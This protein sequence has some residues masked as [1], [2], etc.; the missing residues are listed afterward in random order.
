MKKIISVIGIFLVLVLA[1]VYFYFS[2]KEYVVEI[3]EA[4]IRAKIA[5]KI[6]LTKSFL[7][8]FRV[9][10]KNPRIE[11]VNGSNRINGGFDVVL[12]IRLGKEAKNLGGSLDISGGVRYVPESG[13]FY[14][15]DPIIENLSVTGI[16]NIH[17]KSVTK[18][19]SKIL[20]EFY[21]E[22]PIYTLDGFKAKESAVKMILK[23]IVVEEKS[24]VIT[25]G[26]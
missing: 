18:G 2:G 24:L 26:I 10:L 11:L 14:L 21:A 20:S 16:P 6:P 15:N 17:E 12:N 4:E 22:H 19:L 9:D 13:E 25:L 3:P 23:N 5:E 8:I 7:L 1:G